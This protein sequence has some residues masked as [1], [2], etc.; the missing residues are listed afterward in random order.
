MCIYVEC[1]IHGVKFKSDYMFCKKKTTDSNITLDPIISKQ[2]LKLVSSQFIICNYFVYLT[3]LV[4]S[5]IT[6]LLVIRSLN[7]IISTNCAHRPENCC[8]QSFNHFVRDPY[9]ATAFQH[10]YPLP[11]PHSRD[12]VLILIALL[13]R[14]PGV[15]FLFVFYILAIICPETRNGVIRPRIRQRDCHNELA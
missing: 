3:F 5:S 11:D 7:Q 12:N 4:Y 6:Q 14:L 1:N 10:C 13:C 15:C 9:S 2:L 8:T